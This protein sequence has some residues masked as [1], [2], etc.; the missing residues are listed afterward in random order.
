[1]IRCL[2]FGHKPSE[3][4]E[5]G[6]FG[7]HR[8]SYCERCGQGVTQ[9]VSVDRPLPHGFKTNEEREDEWLEKV[10][11]RFTSSRFA[12]KLMDEVDIVIREVLEEH[13]L[14][15]NPRARATPVNKRERRS[16]RKPHTAKGTAKTNPKPLNH[17][18][19]G[20]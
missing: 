14:S 19:G 11:A 8:L 13:G 5:Y 4:F 6:R 20:T 7:A 16:K 3:M 18:R 15:K 2:L 1:M 9:L 10:E 12:D 17:S